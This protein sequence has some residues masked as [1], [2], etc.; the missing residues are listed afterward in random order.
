MTTAPA[1]NDTAMTNATR[2]VPTGYLHALT[3]AR[4]LVA[5]TLV[6]EGITTVAF[7]RSMYDALAARPAPYATLYCVTFVLMVASF[8]AAHA[9]LRKARQAA[10]QDGFHGTLPAVRN[11]ALWS[12]WAVPP[13]WVGFMTV[14][15][16]ML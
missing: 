8:V 12:L 11:A 7:G 5:L 4:T 6:F 14:L 13:M 3:A 1:L 16:S 9:C 10:R 2:P 15:Q